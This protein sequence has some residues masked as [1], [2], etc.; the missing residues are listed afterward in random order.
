M[1]KKISA[2][3][4]DELP[5]VTGGSIPTVDHRYKENNDH[6]STY[7]YR[8]NV[9]GQEYSVIGSTRKPCPN[10]HSKS[11]RLADIIY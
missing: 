9:C 2:L 6:E 3:T 10:C 7:I 11:G 1:S 4:A 8:C 5:L